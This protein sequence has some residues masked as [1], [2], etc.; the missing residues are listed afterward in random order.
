MTDLQTV[1]NPPFFSGYN[2]EGEYWV[3]YICG[4]AIQMRMVI[5]L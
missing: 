3:V 5:P 1:Y 2:F 4:D